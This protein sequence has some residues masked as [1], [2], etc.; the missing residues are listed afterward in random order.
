MKILHLP[1]IYFPDAAAGTEFYVQALVH[2]LTQLGMENLVVA[3]GQRH[4]RYLHAGIQVVRLATTPGS[5]PL[6]ALYGD[7]DDHVARQFDELLA[8]WQPDVVHFHAFTSAVSLQ[9][10]KA[11]RRRHIPAVVTY[12]TPSASCPRGTLL[13]WGKEV[14]DGELL[15][16]RCSQCVL[17][18]LGMNRVASIAL[19]ALP[20]VLGCRLGD[21]GLEGGLWTALRMSELIHLRNQATHDYWQLADRVVV[22]CDWAGQV[23]RRNGVPVEKLF[24]SRHGL[25]QPIPSRPERSAIRA[26]ADPLRLVFLG[27]IERVKGIDLLI[28]AMRRLPE[29]NLTLDLYGIAQGDSGRAYQAALQTAAAADARI[30]FRPPMQGETVIERL[31]AY[32]A[33]LV[34]SQWLETGP[35]V[36]LEAFAAGIPVVGSNLGGIAEWVVHEKNGLLVSPFD[37]IEAWIDTLRRLS[38]EADLL[39]KLAQG[40]T[41]PRTMAAVAE[42]MFALYQA[43]R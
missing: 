7:G 12:H 15:T 28:D 38:T 16:R 23:L 6:R 9:L 29:A 43:L 17:H 26:A 40:V 4:E 8:E 18:G 13:R 42:E 11:T 1:Y 5:L 24:L 19:G 2:G 35:L 10:M 39:S 20:P 21:A 41:P 3:P 31:Q 37:D 27:R 25:A 22:L 36:V 30:R 14:C 34:P 33:L 32:D